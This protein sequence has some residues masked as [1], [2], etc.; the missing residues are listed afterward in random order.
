MDV[1]EQVM[2][3]LIR[4]RLAQDRRT[5]G[6]SID[7]LVADGDIY[8]L[9]QVDSDDQRTAAETIVEGLVG[10]RQVVS[11]IEIRSPRSPA[12]LIPW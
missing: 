4:T 9:G 3:G 2:A 7:V 12:S 8:L 11:S 6:Q 10:V 1:R 5:G